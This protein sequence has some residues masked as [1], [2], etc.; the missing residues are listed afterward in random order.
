MRKF[1]EHYQ[2]AG[3]LPVKLKPIS[4]FRYDENLWKYFIAFDNHGEFYDFFD[5]KKKQ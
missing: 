4:K 5:A 1:L 3:A 2:Q